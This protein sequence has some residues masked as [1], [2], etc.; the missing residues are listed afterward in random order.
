MK[1]RW[2]LFWMLALPAVPMGAENSADLASTGVLILAHGHE[3]DWNRQ[4]EALTAHFPFPVELALGMA[5]KGAI[6]DGVRRLEKRGVGRIVVVPL[7]I[8]SYSAI[9]RASAYLLGLAEKA[10]P[11]LE[12]FNSMS[13]GLQDPRAGSAEGEELADLSPIR[14]ALPIYMT[15]ALDDHPLV[16]E[17]LLD[18]ARSISVNPG[19]ETVILVGHGAETEEDEAMWQAKMSRLAATIKKR[20]G[21]FGAEVVTVL[22]DAPK[23]LRDRATARLRAGV[24]RASGS[25]TALVIPLLLSRGGIE[26][27]LRQRLSGLRYRIPDNFL[28]PDARIVEWVGQQVE[29]ALR[30]RWAG[31]HPE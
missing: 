30:E 22:D 23:E 8:S 4:V 18:R 27:G 31:K 7:Y 24:E 29:Q 19:R 12:M 25:G 6:S 15:S 10:P 9:I 5:H 26:D 2:L 11:E 1:R 13:H 3:Q 17:I 14:S 16:A 28:L 20:G 21:F